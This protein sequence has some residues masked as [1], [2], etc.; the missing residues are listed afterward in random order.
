MNTIKD[1]SRRANAPIRQRLW[2]AAVKDGDCLIWR[3]DTFKRTMRYGILLYDGNKW[4]AHRLAYF[5]SHGT[6]PPGMYVCH[7]C[8]RTRCIN[9]A[10]LFL[11]T[12]A[13]NARDGHAKG[14]YPVGKNHPARTMPQTRPR[15]NNHWA[16]KL[17]AKQVREIRS[18][19]QRGWEG[20]S[21]ASV[22]GVGRTQISRIINH[23]SWAHIE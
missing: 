23:Q 14:R 17:D 19:S 12:A 6:I 20:K 7:T 3:P 1:F 4:S 11:G 9:P 21:L 10:H 18:L 16:A 15:G 13:D 22:Y 5:L 8:D 2:G